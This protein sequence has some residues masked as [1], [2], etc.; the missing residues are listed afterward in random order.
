M[1]RDFSEIAS[2]NSLS[3]YGELVVDLEGY[4]GPLDILL[5]LARQQKVDLIQISIL[6]LARTIFVVYRRSSTFTS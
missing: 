1:T 6:Q 5:V 3:P 2:F 4:E